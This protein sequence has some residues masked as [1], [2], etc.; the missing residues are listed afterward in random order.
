MTAT[1]RRFPIRT[2]AVVAVLGVAGFGFGYLGSWPPVA[3]VM[4]GS[5]SPTIKTGDVVVFKRLAGAAGVGDIVEV[6]VPDEARS[7]YGYPPVVIHRI[8]RLNAD[9]TVTTK[10]D[11]RQT[12]DPFT[13]RRNSINTRVLFAIPAAGRVFAFL[14]SPLGLLWIVGGVAMFFVLPLFERR[15][16]TAQAEHAALTAMQAELHAITGELAR[17]RVEP[18]Q[19]GAPEE[20]VLVQAP[21]PVQVEAPPA[22]EEPMPSADITSTPKIDW[23]DLETVDESHLEPHWPEAPEFMPGYVP[24]GQAPTSDAEPESDP[25]PVTYTVRRRSGGLLSRFL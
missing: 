4:S 13:V 18:V 8:V 15:E 9:G 10:G 11:A 7:R 3:T 23:L 6:N 12:P 17:L 21:E 16:E 14:A 25:E 22:E 19:A 2:A 24:F 20:P 1:L 5:M